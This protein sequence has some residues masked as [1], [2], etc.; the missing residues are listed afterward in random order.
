VLPVL[1]QLAEVRGWTLTA[2]AAT[3]TENARALFVRE[4]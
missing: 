4:R 3:T 2:A 1:A